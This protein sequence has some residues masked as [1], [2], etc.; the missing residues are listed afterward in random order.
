[1]E[2]DIVLKI[3]NNKYLWLFDLNTQWL[4]LVIQICLKL[5]H[6]FGETI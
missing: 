4:E 6:R 1:M 2:T 5:V 3:S